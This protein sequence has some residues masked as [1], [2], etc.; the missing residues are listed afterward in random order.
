MKSL[1]TAYL[2][3][4]LVNGVVV[5]S[6]A[7]QTGRAASAPQ[8]LGGIAFCGGKEQGKRYDIFQ[9]NAD[10]SG[11]RL[12]TGDDNQR[13][14][15][16][17]CPAWSP[18]GSELAF[19]STDGRINWTSHAGLFIVDPASRKIRLLFRDDEM[20][21]RD[22]AWAPDGKRLVFAR[23]QK[24]KKAVGALH[25]KI[26]LICAQEQLFSIKSDGSGLQQLTHDA[27]FN[28][29]PAWSPDGTDIAYMSGPPKEEGRK[30]DI[31]IMQ[32]DGSN[33]RKLTNGGA[34]EV[35][36]DPAWSPDGKEVAFCSNRT[37]SY[38]LYVVNPD[39]TN[40]RQITHDTPDGV[41][42]PSWAPDGRQIVFS[43][44]SGKA[45]PL[46]IVNS[47]GTN[48]RVVTK[49]GWHPSVGRTPE[50]GSAR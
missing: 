32:A 44:A 1:F 4:S 48:V 31:L 16:N 6:N 15:W 26:A 14:Q 46:R 41:R 43:A 8:L 24:T 38:E 23:G 10:G 11:M 21:P 19:A 30:A 2:L 49:V 22:P 9:V 34:N 28:A 47:D 5:P 33:P 25:L 7:Q 39:G 42:L 17:C 45:W 12:I 18:D 3:F 27:N 29:R 13:W 20:W 50:W 37:G 36:G 35:N 40:L